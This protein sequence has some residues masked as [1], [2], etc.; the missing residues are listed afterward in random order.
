[1]TPERAAEIV[2]AINER[3]L[4]QL[5]LVASVKPLTDVSLAEMLEAKTMVQAANVAARERQKAEGE[6][7]TISVVPDDRIIAAAYT[8]EHFLPSNEAV[9]VVPTRQWPYD[10][11]VLAVVGL[12]PGQGKDDEDD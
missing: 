3:A 12:E 11:R 8:L 6:S 1:M 10:R 4:F 5:D 9:A 2:S 7:I